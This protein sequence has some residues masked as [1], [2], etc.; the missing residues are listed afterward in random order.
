LAL[1]GTA[2]GFAAYLN[3]HF[4]GDGFTQG[5]PVAALHEPGTSLG[6]QWLAWYSS[7]SREYGDEYTLTQY[8]EAFIVL[9]T[10]AMTNANIETGISGGATGLGSVV[11]GIPSGISSFNS[12]LGNTPEDIANT[13]S[14]AT[15]WEQSLGNFFQVLSSKN[16]WIRIGEGVAAVIILYVGLKA[17]TT[18]QGQAVNATAPIKKAASWIPK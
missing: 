1:P 5:A 15:S 14:A 9:W 16:L 11:T 12:A 6:E 7:M 13:Y 17:L 18:P 10:D 3:Q 4:Q 8:E 2:N